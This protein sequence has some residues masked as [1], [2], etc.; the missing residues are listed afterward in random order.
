[1]KC[2]KVNYTINNDCIIR[3]DNQYN[4]ISVFNRHDGTYIR[5]GIIQ[6]GKETN[7]DPFIASFPHLIDVGIMGHCIHGQKKLCI[8]AGIECYQS[9]LIKNEPNMSLENFEKICKESKGLV[10]QFALGGRGDPDCHENFEEILKLCRTYS[11]VP[12]YTTSGLLMNEEKAKLTKE[13]CGAVAISWYR[14]AYT[15]KAIELFLNEKVKTNIH[16]VVDKYSID[17]AIQILKDNSLPKGINAIIFLLFKPVGQGSLGRV[18]KYNDERLKTFF[19]LI[20]IKHPYKIGFDSCFVP[21]ILNNMTN[22]NLNS[23]DT[24]EAARFSMYISPDMKALPCSFDQSNKYAY[25]IRN[26]D[27]YDAWISDEFQMFR[28]NLK[29]SCNHCVKKKYCM[30]GC[31]LVKQIVLCEEKNENKN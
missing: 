25:D 21:G 13:Y 9:G 14:S 12:N 22:I 29:S 7:V 2:N 4:F 5:S 24:C 8:K 3:K 31:P 6:D 28:N 26:K 11:I 18:I 16:F 30:G 23:I 17:E 1:M 27:I 20:S 19:N 10:D 15:K